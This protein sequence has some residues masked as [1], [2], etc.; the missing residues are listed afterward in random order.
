MDLKPVL[1]CHI[2]FQLWENWCKFIH[3]EYISIIQR[4]N[5]TK[6]TKIYKNALVLVNLQ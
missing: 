2:A 1:L 5:E 3:T 4:N 6:S